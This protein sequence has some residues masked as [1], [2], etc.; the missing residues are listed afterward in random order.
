MLLLKFAFLTMLLELPFF[1]IFWRNEGLGQA[2]LFCILLNGFTNPILNV[3]LL[4]SN[5]SVY[6]LE[7]T[8]FFTEALIAWRLFRPSMRKAMLFSALANG[9]SFGAGLVMHELNWL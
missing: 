1:L 9:F 6:W 2:I 4:N 5:T 3:V 7:L 8:V